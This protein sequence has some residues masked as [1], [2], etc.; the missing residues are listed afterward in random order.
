M[1][2]KGEKSFKSRFRILRNRHSS[3]RDSVLASLQ[4]LRD[5]D[6]RYKQAVALHRKDKHEGRKA[7]S[8]AAT[9]AKTKSREAGSAA[10]TA[11]AGV[12]CP[13]CKKK[14]K[15]WQYLNVHKKKCAAAKLQYQV[16]RFSIVQPMCAG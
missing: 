8:A 5:C 4:N 9:A 15:Q 7:K 6:C 12:T 1:S 13:Y 14:F 10:A 16:S 11:A 2:R 3:T